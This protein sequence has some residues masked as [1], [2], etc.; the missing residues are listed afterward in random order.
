[1]KTARTF[2]GQ[3]GSQWRTETTQLTDA[4]LDHG[5]DRGCDFALVNTDDKDEQFSLIEFHRD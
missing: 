3:G 5:G 4:V 1:M 2:T